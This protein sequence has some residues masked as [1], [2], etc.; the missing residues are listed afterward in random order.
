[1]KLR[2]D[3]LKALYRNS[4]G[5]KPDEESSCPSDEVIL[6]SFTPEMSEEEK[7]RL[8]DHASACA[9]C[10]PRF[11]AARE[12][13]MGAKTLAAEFEGRF[14]SRSETAE[15][16]GRAREKM[17]RRESP[18]HRKVILFR[19]RY[20]WVAAG[21]IVVFL[22]AWI[23]VQS[24]RKMSD[25]MIRG[26]TG[27]AVEL[28]TP[29]GTLEKA[30]SFFR[31]TPYPGA[32]EYEIRVLNDRLDAVW[33]SGGIK[34]NRAALPAAVS[35]ALEKGTVYYWKVTVRLEGGNVVESRLQEFRLKE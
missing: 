11:Q 20:A 17:K 3:D 30:P 33:A 10:G 35:E 15:L 27:A 7:L 32:S 21:F 22:A 1:M 6:R 23:A 13:M 12:I 25:T 26:E 24:P 28:E 18:S 5:R 19:Y 4:V 9:V 29:R 2:H 8:V 34:V 16:K 14:V 31:W